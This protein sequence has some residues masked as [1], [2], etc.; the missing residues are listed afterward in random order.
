MNVLEFGSGN[1]AISQ[2]V[3]HNQDG[4]P[5][6]ALAIYASNSG[7]KEMDVDHPVEA[8]PYRATVPES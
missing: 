1:V 5:V 2:C 7:S 3:G 4:V 6:A 8:I